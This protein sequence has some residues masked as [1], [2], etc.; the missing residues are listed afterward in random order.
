MAGALVVSDEFD[1]LLTPRLR[2]L[3]AILQLRLVH[4]W[5]HS[6]FIESSYLCRLRYICFSKRTR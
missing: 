3:T 5:K 6:D 1:S 4:E 2:A